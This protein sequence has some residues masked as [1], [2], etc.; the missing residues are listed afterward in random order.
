M[1]CVFCVRKGRVFLIRQNI[2]KMLVWK[3]CFSCLVEICLMFWVGYCWVVLL[4]SMFSFLQVFIMDCMVLWQNFGELMLLGISRQGVFRVWMFFWVSCV[5]F[6][7][8]RQM[9]VS[10][11]FFC[12]YV[13]V[14]VWL[15][16]LLLFVMRVILFVSCCLG[17]LV[18]VLCGCG[19]IFCLLFG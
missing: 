3:V 1:M 19:C 6:F 4:I 7:L 8:F 17:W 18:G 16:L 14:M 9:M 13:S 10:F 5:F 15:M 12:V 11:V 2:E